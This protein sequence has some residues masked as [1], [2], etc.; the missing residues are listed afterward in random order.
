MNY[1][2]SMVGHLDFN[3]SSVSNILKRYQNIIF[4]LDNTLYKETDYLFP[5]YSEIAKK[6]ELS[7]GIKSEIISNYLINEFTQ[8]GREN[9]FNKLIINYQLEESYLSLAIKILRN[10]KPS[11]KILL[12]QKM[13]EFIITAYKAAKKLFILTN[14]NKIQQTNKISCIN[15]PIQLD[16]INIIFAND[17]MPKPS[18]KALIFIIKNFNLIRKDTLMIGDI[19]TDELCAT[20]GGVNF[21]YVDK[22]NQKQS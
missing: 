3:K 7:E 13:H 1:T 9:L 10:H 2:L 14:G 21:L 18:A 12:Y 22:I 16:A 17:F 19:Y 20:R 5:A 15:W 6:I 8:F 11:Q 4:D